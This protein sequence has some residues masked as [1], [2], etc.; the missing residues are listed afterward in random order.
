MNCPFCCEPVADAATVCKTCRRDISVP[1]PLMEANRK[2]DERVRALEAELAELRTAAAAAAPVERAPV[3]RPPLGP[4]GAV[5]RFLVLPILLI[6][7]AHYLL[8]IKFDARLVW[9][10]AASIVLPAL[11]GYWLEVSRGPRWYVVVAAGV[12]TAL[13]SVFGMSA[14]VSLVD[15]DPLLPGSAVVWRE[16]LEYAASIALAYM[17]GTLIAN[18][19]HPALAVRLRARN[20]LVQLAALLAVPDKDGKAKAGGTLEQRIERLVKLMNLG[21]SAATAAGAIYAGFKG[22]L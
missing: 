18:T 12:A 2:L 9:L 1:R 16:T 11:F 13:A 17:L 8:V 7:L 4:A 19:F 10:R 5:L 20:P 22:I 14:V 15:G 21:I 6:L 3:E